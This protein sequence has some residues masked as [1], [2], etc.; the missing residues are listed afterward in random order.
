MEFSQ[1][2]VLVVEDDPAWKVIYQELLGPQ[3]EGF[4]VR[5]ADNRDD[6]VSALKEDRFDLVIAD[7]KLPASANSTLPSFDNGSAVIDAIVSLPTR[8][9]VIVNTGYPQVPLE[10]ARILGHLGAPITFEKTRGARDLL[11]KVKQ[12]ALLQPRRIVMK[13]GGTSMGSSESIWD[14]STLVA[15]HTQRGV[16]HCVVVVSAMSKVTDTLLVCTSDAE[17][18]DLTSVGERIEN[19]RSRHMGVAHKL[20]TNL[21]EQL[22][23]QDTL[24]ESCQT[25]M[26]MYEGIAA[27]REIT[28]RT[29]DRIAGYGERLSARLLSGV[30]ASRGVLSI[31]VDATQLII[32]DYVFG[33]AS[34]NMVE[35]SRRSEAILGPL[36]EQGVV[37]VVTGFIASTEDGIATTLGRGGSDYS[38][39]I[40][41]AALNAS[42]VQIWT[43]V[44]GI[45]DADPNLVPGAAT[46]KQISYEKA[47]ELTYHGAKVLHAKALT[48]VIGKRIPVRILNT[49]EPDQ[50]GT[51]IGP[52]DAVSYEGG[53][54]VSSSGF[55]LVT[56]S[57]DLDQTWTPA[58][59]ARALAALTRDDVEV[60]GYSQGFSRR[61]LSILVR[62]ADSTRAVSVLSREFRN[63]SSGG[64]QRIT[65]RGKVAAVSIVGEQR[66]PSRH[67]GHFLS[68]L[69]TNGID[70]LGVIEVPTEKSFS[71]LVDQADLKTAVRVAH[72]ATL[73]PL[74]DYRS[75]AALDQVTQ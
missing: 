2:K 57:S 53:V 39:T 29:L 7:L 17:R 31:A 41:G 20:I 70:L 9:N 48:P 43:D 45:K 18:G 36:L 35:T 67:F 33:S 47:A 71:V 6:A 40:L 63:G 64:A 58:I 3:G 24:D 55:G 75:E 30:L 69:G 12:Q 11:E 5:M 22:R 15:R 23:F 73:A 37:P 1:V 34:P 66:T 28:P 49:F 21:E 19:L 8:P 52:G 60:M 16:R 62:E 56:I 4:L 27:L 25:L 42:E 51:L 61:T 44:T 26:Q 14:V 13:F 38:A 46:I 68:G 32:T 74:N 65:A 72:Q 50:P 54:L 59:G 10:V